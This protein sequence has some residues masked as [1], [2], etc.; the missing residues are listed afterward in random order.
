MITS[1][2][3]YLSLKLRLPVSVGHTVSLL[4]FLLFLKVLVASHEIVLKTNL[5][6]A[7]HGLG[8]IT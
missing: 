6:V 3:Y 1:L 7:I 8:K 5:L 2:D 4:L